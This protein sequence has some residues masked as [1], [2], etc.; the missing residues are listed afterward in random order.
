MT[1]DC[2]NDECKVHSYIVE[3]INELKEGQS[4]MENITKELKES[5]IRLEEVQSFV[6]QRHEE[7]KEHCKEVIG[8]LE[9]RDEMQDKLIKSNRDVLIAFTA[10]ITFL[11]FAIPLV[12][13]YY[14][15]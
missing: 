4:K 1:F 6:I 12:M 2:G 14:K 5:T 9:G 11:T 7:Y 15:G 10:V 8:K 13:Q 3:A